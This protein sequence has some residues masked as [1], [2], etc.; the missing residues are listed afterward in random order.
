MGTTSHL[1]D[2]QLNQYLDGVLDPGQVAGLE[3]HLA[4]C[5]DCQSRLTDLQALF[6]ALEALPEAPLGRDLTPQVMAALQPPPIPW[7]AGRWVAAFQVATAVAVL[8]I[9]W[10]LLQSLVPPATTLQ[11]QQAL[12]DWLNQTL[13]GLAAGLEAW[14]LAVT[15]WVQQ[16]L[17]LARPS[18]YIPGFA[19]NLWPWLA[20]LGLLWLL[21]NGLLLGPVRQRSSNGYPNGKE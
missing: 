15:A 4:G 18:A 12:A 16:A 7:R 14:R 21:G 3:A 9:S 13:A 1:N 6:S 11:F 2:D 19:A 10:P 17:A 8:L 5:G 20:A